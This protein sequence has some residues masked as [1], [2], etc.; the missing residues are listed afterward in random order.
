MF[1][2]QGHVAVPY[3]GEWT[4]VESPAVSRV[5]WRVGFSH[6]ADEE[7]N[8][9]EARRFFCPKCVP[10]NLSL[11]RTGDGWLLVC[12]EYPRHCPYSRRPSLDDVKAL[13]RLGG[14]TCTD[15]HPLTARTSANGIFL[16]CENYPRCT[17]TSNLS[18]LAGV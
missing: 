5:I 14:W 11:R 1:V 13:V 6:L 4:V 10:G 18:L 17:F 9:N 12:S 16:G 7:V 3:G 15:G 8:P 2:A